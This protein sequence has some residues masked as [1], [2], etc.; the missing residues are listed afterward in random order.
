VPVCSC[1]LWLQIVAGCTRPGSVSHNG[2]SVAST[3]H[4]PGGTRSC[5][6]RLAPRDGLGSGERAFVRAILDGGFSNVP[7]FFPLGRA[8]ER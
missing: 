2:S 3:G 1:R 8:T 5:G 7:T 6:R 4:G